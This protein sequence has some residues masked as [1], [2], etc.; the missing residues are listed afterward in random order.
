VTRDHSTRR[1]EKIVS[2]HLT[3]EGEMSWAEF[4]RTVNMTGQ[5]L[6]TWLLTDASGEAAF[7]ATPGMEWTEHRR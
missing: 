4:H 2:D 3:A 5:E 7:P 1:E 6:R